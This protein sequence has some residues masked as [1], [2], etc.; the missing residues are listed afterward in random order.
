MKPFTMMRQVLILY[1][2]FNASL[3]AMSAVEVSGK[4][5]KPAQVD[6][7]VP[8]APIMCALPQDL[9]WPDLTRKAKAL[10]ALERVHAQEKKDAEA[11]LEKYN[12]SCDI[13]SDSTAAYI[14]AAIGQ[15]VTIVLPAKLARAL[16]DYHLNVREIDSAGVSV[17]HHACLAK[18]HAAVLTLLLTGV[19]T[20]AKDIDGRKAIDI[21][22]RNGDILSVQ[23]LLFAGIKTG[24]NKTALSTFIGCP[25]LLNAIWWFS[26]NDTDCWFSRG[27]TDVIDRIA[28]ICLLL[29][30]G[31]RV[32]HVGLD[33]KIDGI[34][35]LL[36]DWEKSSEENRFG[37]IVN[38]LQGFGVSRDECRE[39]A[40]GIMATAD[41]VAVTQNSK[42]A[43]RNRILNGYSC[44][45]KQRKTGPL[46][47]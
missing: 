1:C 10:D 43:V 17:L 31:A 41:L 26:E 3:V 27:Q 38:T 32:E 36:H 47:F 24:D 7:K 4:D 46:C 45:Y 12:L 9:V 15:L 33:M 21:A 2:A 5:S 14:A 35:S 13:D 30:A 25:M 18:D 42:A 34:D 40:T 29:A 23:Y 19:D 44:I 16:R 11:L 28:I 37:L 20:E 22:I 8:D 39:Q 6:I